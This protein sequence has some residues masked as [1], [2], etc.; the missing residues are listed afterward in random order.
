MVKAGDPLVLLVPEAGSRAVELYVDGN[1]APLVEPGRPV[2]IQFEGWPAVQFVGWPSV[3][4]GTFPGEVAFIDAHDDGKG[5]F[6]VVVVPTE[7]DAWP[8]GRYLRQGV[9][10]NGWVL[11][12]RVKLG[13]ELWRR[14]NGF[15]P[16]LDESAKSGGLHP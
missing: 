10:A 1:D 5:R 6:R 7:S 16:A 2:R 15:P 4:V 9:R 3:A 13:F 11:L 12:N 14:F 8:E